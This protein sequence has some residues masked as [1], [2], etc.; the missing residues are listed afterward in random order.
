MSPSA[1]RIPWCIA[2]LLVLCQGFAWAQEAP[3]KP[4]VHPL[5]SDNM[6]L[7]RDIA[8]PVWGWAK[9]GETVKVTLDG[10]TVEGTADAT[11]K[12]RVNVGPFPA[13]G[14]HEVTIA[15]SQT[16]TLKNVLFGDVW[17]C[18]GQSNMQFGMWG[19]N[20]SQEEIAA[21]DHPQ[22]RLFSVP[23]VVGFE[24]QELVAGQWQV[25]S[26]QAVGGFTAV[27]YFFGRK[28]NAD[29][30]VPI[31]LIH[32]S[33]GGTI[34]EAWTS[35]EA[36]KTMPDF[37]PAVDALHKLVEDQA[38]LQATFE[39]QMDEWW[40]KNDPGSAAGAD[41]AAPTLNAAAWKTMS[42]P[43]NWEDGGLPD[44]D[45]IVWFRK[46]V[47]VPAAW[48]GKEGT[49]HL[50]PVDDRDTTFVNGEQVGA[51]DTWDKPRDYQLPAGLLK[52]GQNL[53]AVRVL[54][55]GGG[56]GLYGQPD[57]MKLEA[58][59]GAGIPLAGE[60]QY[61]AAKPLA[62]CTP[63]PQRLENNPNQVSVLYNAMIA[64]LV[65]FAIKGAIWYQ[66]ESN[67]GRAEQYARLLPTLIQDWRTR[68]GVG[69]FPF[70]IVQLANFLPVDDVPKD[71][72]WPNLRWSQWLTTK[73]L[74]NV[75]MACIIDIGEAGD[76]HPKN[77]QD[78]GARLAL[79]AE[80]MTYGKDVECSGPVYKAMDVEG[81]KVR[82]TFD[83]LGGGLV[84][85]GDRL[86]GFAIAGADGQFAWADAT[87][88]GDT[89]VVSSPQ[90]ATPTTVRY[91]WSNNPVC[92]LYNQAGLPA[93]PFATDK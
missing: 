15:G 60:W 33:W 32:S 79:V 22:M 73:A 6:V 58:A 4:F 67:A 68:F 57:Q 90:V 16:V 40:A 71:D 1:R 9:P 89:V 12:W 70:L 48:Q 38:K 26:P 46:T 28:L 19:T 77:K 83:H 65:P 88:D 54:D 87:V 51:T 2:A 21:A 24:P 39:Q 5:F 27:G 66:G 53:I 31:G 74:P 20:N 76:I 18:S 43:C 72:P 47:D 91:A 23:N 13:G 62:E 37:A 10:K 49:L 82:L 64:P 93:V 52:T 45:G 56:G 7:Q 85:K 63:Q 78:V 80:K 3:A 86:E 36:L 81:S 29:L 35:A 69:D 55:T 44:F 84:V 14:P 8:C 11:G 59:D 75:G 34:A 61:M 17:I 42:L 41:W 25:C 30:N 92:N 50:G